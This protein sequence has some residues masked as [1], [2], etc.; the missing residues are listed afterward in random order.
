MTEDDEKALKAVLEVLM[1][2]R[3]SEI[4]GAMMSHHIPH[5]GVTGTAFMHL[6]L[7]ILKQHGSKSEV[8]NLLLNLASVVNREGG[9]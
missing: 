4:V 9:K 6:G 8:E 7:C 5:D 3:E 1:T 2:L